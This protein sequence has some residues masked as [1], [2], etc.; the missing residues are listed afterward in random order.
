[1]IE[2]VNITSPDIMKEKSKKGKIVKELEYI[3]KHNA[4]QEQL[5]KRIVQEV[6]KIMNIIE[7]YANNGMTAY[8]LE[9][10]NNHFGYTLNEVDVA[11]GITEV[12]KKA[13]YDSNYYVYSR[14]WNYKSKKVCNV[15]ISW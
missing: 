4:Y 8:S 14:S 15:F 2:V 7:D 11:K 6:E 13:G 1:M 5:E 12:F 10:Y 9:I 3:R